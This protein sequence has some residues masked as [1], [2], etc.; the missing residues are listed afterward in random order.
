MIRWVLPRGVVI[1]MVFALVI[2]GLGGTGVETV[3][4]RLGGDFPAFYGVGRLVL[5]GKQAEMYA[6]EVQAQI[7]SDLLSESD[8]FLYFA[9]P[10]CTPGLPLP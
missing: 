2:A 9:Y 5:E 8:E 6:P 3:S 7:Q 10:P 1:G 4:G